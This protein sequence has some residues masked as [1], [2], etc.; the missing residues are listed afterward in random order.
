[1]LYTIEIRGE[2]RKYNLQ[3]QQFPTRN[4]NFLQ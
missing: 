1:M 2:G 4:N 3:Q